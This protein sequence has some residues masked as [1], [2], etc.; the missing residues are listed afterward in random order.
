VTDGSGLFV[1]DYEGLVF[2]GG[3]FISLFVASGRGAIAAEI[4]SAT[5]ASGVDRSHNGHTEVNRYLLRRTVERRKKA[6]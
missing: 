5:R 4:F 1:G 6:K 3:G 2:A